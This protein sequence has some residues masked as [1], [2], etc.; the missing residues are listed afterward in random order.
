MTSRGTVSIGAPKLRAAPNINAPIIATLAEGTS[1][2][3]LAQAGDWLHVRAEGRE[4]YLFADYVQVTPTSAPVRRIGKVN[5]RDG[6]NLRRGPNTTQPIL[7][8]LGFETELEVLGEPT[9]GWLRVRVGDIEGFVA[10]QYVTVAETRRE[11]QPIYIPPLEERT[12][13]APPNLIPPM[14]RGVHASAGGWAPNDKELEL[15]RANNIGAV[16]IAA[17]EPGQARHAITLFRGVGV[18][19]FVIRAATHTPISADPN[20][21]INATLPILREY[22]AALGGAPFIIQIH[23]EP[24]LRHEGW[25]SAWTDGH[26][27]TAWFMSVLNAYRQAFPTAKL[28]YPALSPGIDVPHL[29]LAEATF[30]AQSLEAVRA[31]DWFAVHA[32]WQQPDGSDLIT[33]VAQWRAWA[34]SKPIIATEVGPSDH[35]PVTVPAVRRAYARFASIGIPAMAWLLNGAGAW[36]NADWTLHNIRI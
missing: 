19:H 28:G 16:M 14:I 27:F 5:T 2:S 22:Q 20:V 24:N 13:G 30:M 18:Q 6:L 15:I 32:Y 35:T 36:L 7:R 23:N 12:I 11:E 33:P 26:G 17:Y 31:A 4:G 8:V 25:Q 21:F 34:Q 1:I 3:I 9:D 10:A 29:R